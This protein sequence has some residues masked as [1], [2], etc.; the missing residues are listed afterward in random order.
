[1]ARTCRSNER[2]AVDKLRARA[3]EL[4]GIVGA[5]SEKVCESCAQNR[6]HYRRSL[7]SMQVWKRR[8]KSE[9]FLR[10]EEVVEMKRFL[11]AG[12]AVVDSSAP[13]SRRNTSK[14]AKCRSPQ[15]P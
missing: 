6:E 7:A 5:H 9:C 1:M 13:A 15:E 2:L 8:G 14:R 11:F 3:S 4:H 12:R 10:Q